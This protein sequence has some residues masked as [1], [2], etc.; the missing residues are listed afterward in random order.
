MDSLTD[1][2]HADLL[3][4]RQSLPSETLSSLE[5]LVHA[6]Q[7]DLA[8][9]RA[10]GTTDRDALYLLSREAERLAA[11]RDTLAVLQPTDAFAQLKVLFDEDV[12]QRAAAAALAGSQLENA[13]AFLDAAFGDSQEM[14]MF[15][16]ELTANFFTSWYIQNFGSEAYFAHNKRLLFDDTQRELLGKISEARRADNDL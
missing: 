3:E 4:V 7:E 10:S 16:T 8:R 2:L 15:A 5:Q 14:V 11:Y 1:A 6:R 13:F 12:R 9:R